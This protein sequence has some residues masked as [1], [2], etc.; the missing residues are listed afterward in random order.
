M[1]ED[2]KKKIGLQL[3]NPTMKSILSREILNLECRIFI[4]NQ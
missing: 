1:R 4:I 2:V 3:T